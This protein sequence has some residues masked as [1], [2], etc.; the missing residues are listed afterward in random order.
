VP[1]ALGTVVDYWRSI[2]GGDFGGAYALLAPGSVP[3]TE[4][5]F[6]A[7][8]RATRISSVHFAGRLLALAPRAATVE[9]TSLVTE[10]HRYGCRTWSG[11]YR[12]IASAGRW[13]IA[14]AVIAPGPCGA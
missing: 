11:T 10:D 14:R 12:L 5:A 2:E 4:T 8:E 6:A 9:V 3:L 7:Y 13:K 1:T